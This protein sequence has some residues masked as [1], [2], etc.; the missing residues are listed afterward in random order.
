MSKRTF[1]ASELII[2]NDGSCFHLHLKPEQ[3]ADRAR[4]EEIPCEPPGDRWNEFI[5]HS[6]R[7]KE[8]QPGSNMGG[9]I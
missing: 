2:N 6:R 9:L 8:H 4:E 1:P 7:G 3:L 5:F